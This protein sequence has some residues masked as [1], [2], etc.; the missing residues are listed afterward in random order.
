MM[1]LPKR[2]PICLSWWREIWDGDVITPQLGVNWL[3]ISIGRIGIIVGSQ[4]HSND[5]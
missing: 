2:I 5:I 4:W 1:W 3:A